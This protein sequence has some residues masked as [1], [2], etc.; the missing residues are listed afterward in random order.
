MTAEEF[1]KK[2]GRINPRDIE[3]LLFEDKG[4]DYEKCKKTLD[5]AESI[6]N[7]IRNKL[8]NKLYRFVWHNNGEI[9]WKE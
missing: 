8:H 2:H 9:E 1:L 3:K 7:E 6:L 5:E 4:L